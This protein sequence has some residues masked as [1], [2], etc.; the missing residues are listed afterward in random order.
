MPGCAG[1]YRRASES[2]QTNDRR[3]RCIET[4]RAPAWQRTAAAVDVEQRR[5]S[6]SGFNQA[7]VSTLSAG[8]LTMHRRGLGL[9]LAIDRRLC[10]SQ[11]SGHLLGPIAAQ[12]REGSSGAAEFGN[13]PYVRK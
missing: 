5:A 8:G 13:A 1:V 7:S 3:Y 11:S 10:L 6:V 9:G 2:I 4:L 12:S